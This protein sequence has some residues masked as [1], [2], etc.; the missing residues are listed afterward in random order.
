MIG[1]AAPV[2]RIEVFVH[3]RDK[4]GDADVVEIKPGTAFCGIGAGS[5]LDTGCRSHRIGVAVGNED[6]EPAARTEE[7]VLVRY[8]GSLEFY[9]CLL[10]FRVIPDESAARD[11]HTETV[12]VLRA[13]LFLEGGGTE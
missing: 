13:H 9:P 6:K 12:V 5:N 4:P 3:V 1:P 11:F 2:L 8:I 7:I 10:R